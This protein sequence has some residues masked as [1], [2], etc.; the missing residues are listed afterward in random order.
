[1][2]MILKMRPLLWGGAPR[3]DVRDVANGIRAGAWLPRT[4]SP[5]A[6]RDTGVAVR[7]T[8]FASMHFATRSIETVDSW[9]GGTITITTTRRSVSYPVHC[10]RT[11][12]SSTAR[13]GITTS[14]AVC[15]IDR[16][17]PDAT[18]S[19]PPRSASPLPDC[20][21]INH[22]DD[23]WRAVLLR[24]Q[25]L[26]PAIAERLPGRGSAGAR[27]CRGTPPTTHSA[28]ARAEFSDRA[29]T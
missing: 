3:P 22:G 13:T 11:I 17:R 21:P 1:M 5:R 6:G 29:A 14:P 15:G 23:T 2:K 9:M 24:E 20:R 16:K 12:E 8:N 7:S 26:L 18:R 19:W 4:R 25:H 27:R 10:R 28:T